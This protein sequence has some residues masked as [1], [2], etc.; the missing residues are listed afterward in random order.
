MKIAIVG[1]GY[2]GLSLCWHF[3]QHDGCEVTL[4]DA[5]GIGAGASGAS[6]GLLHPYPAKLAKRSLRAEEAMREAHALL[7]VAGA[8]VASHSGIVRLA[9]N[10]DQKKAY[11]ASLPDAE[12]LDEEAVKS[13]FPKAISSGGLWI[14]QG[15][16]VFSKP[17]LE[18]LWQACEKRGAKLHLQPLQDLKELD[19][20]D[21]AVLANGHKILS[22]KECAD[23]PLKTRH[24]QALVCR[25]PAS[26][27]P[28]ACSLIGRG[29]LSLSEDP[30]LCLLGATYENTFDPKRVEALREQIGVF[31][32]P[33]RDF[34]ILDVRRGVRIA[35]KEGYLPLVQSISKK[36]WVFTGL[37]SR[38]LL[39][40]G[41]YGKELSL[42]I[43]KS[44]SH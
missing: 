5:N 17:Y 38:G 30:S 9:M 11:Q 20:F 25:W 21:A 27:P 32:P 41:L 3:L 6:T 39:Y 22:F 12:F 34:E 36:V 1:A 40:H 2:G 28:L 8:G 7:E 35:P 44:L 26:E 37:G 33:A 42:E 24:G 16:T 19:A 4:I 31:Y 13:R 14:P 18:G 23:L 43:I 29:H 15:K 10:N